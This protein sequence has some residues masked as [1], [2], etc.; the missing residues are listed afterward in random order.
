MSEIYELAPAKVFICTLAGLGL[1]AQVAFAFAGAWWSSH[2]MTAT[3]L[4][5]AAYLAFAED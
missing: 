5:W 2:L 4:C 1:T 3:V